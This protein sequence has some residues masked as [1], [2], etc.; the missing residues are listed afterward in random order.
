MISPWENNSVKLNIF[1]ELGMYGNRLF[2]DKD[3][4][5]NQIVI[6]ELKD[7]SGTVCRCLYAYD[8]GKI[9]FGNKFFSAI[10]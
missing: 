1:F 6:N 8:I 9:I 10:L 2:L 5:W 4:T 7:C 3:L